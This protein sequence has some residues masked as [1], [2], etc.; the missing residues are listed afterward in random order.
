M[1]TIE[2]D[3]KEGDE[4]PE[5]HL[6]DGEHIERV[7]VALDQ[8]HEKLQGKSTSLHFW[9]ARIA[10]NHRLLETR[11][12][13]CRCKVSLPT[14]LVVVNVTNHAGQIVP[15]GTWSSFEHASRAQGLIAHMF[16]VSRERIHH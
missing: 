13:D 4:E 5:Q 6:D 16:R 1:A 9:S 15:L 3:L 10:N 8:L 12:N 11:G 14:D 2:V 7:I